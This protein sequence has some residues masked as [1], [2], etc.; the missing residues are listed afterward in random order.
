VRGA[1]LAWI[2]FQASRHIGQSAGANL[3]GGL[4]VV[5]LGVL[6]ERVVWRWRGQPPTFHPW[7][8]WA[9]AGAA[10]IAA[11]PLGWVVA[12]YQVKKFA[13]LPGPLALERLAGPR[14]ARVAYA[15]YNQPYFFFGSHFQNDLQIVPRN[16]KLDAQFYH[17]GMEVTDPYVEGAYR[18]WWDALQER[19]IEYVVI[20]RTEWE[21]PERRW[22]SRRTED[23]A[24][25]WAGPREEIWRVKGQ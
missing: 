13:K 16:R 20:V 2:A 11:V 17:W 24:L 8:R 12:T 1:V 6:L 25:A 3:V 18:R 19:G 9:A 14:G 21:E 4:V 7:M 10:V 23:F 15:G 22:V 5:A